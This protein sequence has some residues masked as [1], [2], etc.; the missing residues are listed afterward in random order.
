MHQLYTWSAADRHSLL[1]HLSVD[2]DGPCRLALVARSQEELDSKLALAARRLAESPA[3]RWRHRSGIFFADLN[4]QRGGEPVAFLFPGQGSEYAGMLADARRELP[5]VAAWFDELDQAWGEPR[6]SRF[7]ESDAGPAGV[8]LGG[9]LSTTTGLALAQALSELGVQVSAMAGPSS[10]ENAALICAGAMAFQDRRQLFELLHNLFNHGRQ[11]ESQGNAPEADFLA[12]STEDR[13]LVREILERFCDQLWVALDN[14][15]RQ[16][17]L[18]GTSQAILAAEARL[19]Q[20]GAFSFR[21][22]FRRAYHTPLY[23]PVARELESQVYPLLPMATPQIPVYSC[24][25]AEPYPDDPEAIR[26]LAAEQWATT[27]RFRET[28][29]RM[30]QDG[31]RHFIEVGPGGRLAGFVRDTLRSLPHSAWTTAAEGRSEVAQLLEVAAFLFCEGPARGVQ[32][33]PP[34]P[35]SLSLLTSCQME[36]DGLSASIELSPERQGFLLDHR[37][38]RLPVVPFSFSLELA[39]EAAVQLAGGVAVAV[40][41]ARSLRWLA[42]DHDRLQVEV[43]ARS[44]GPGR[45]SVQIL[46]QDQLSFSCEVLLAA[47]FPE[48]PAALPELPGQPLPVQLEARAYNESLFHGEGLL[49]LWQARAATSQGIEVEVRVPFSHH[50]PWL[51]PADTLDGAGHLAAYWLLQQSQRRFWLFPVAVERLELFGPPPPPRTMLTCRLQIK[52]PGT[53]DLDWIDASGAVAMRMQGFAF[54]WDVYPPHLYDWLHY[55]ERGRRLSQACEEG[56]RL[57]LPAG[58]LESTGGIWRRA[59]VARALTARERLRGSWPLADWI[60]AKEAVQDWAAERGARLELD[61]IELLPD[62]GGRPRVHGPALLDSLEVSLQPDHV[63]VEPGPGVV[64][65]R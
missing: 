14:C 56:R 5:G 53:A 23:A 28:L 50:E 51:L 25:R 47:G 46:E 12:V 22:P 52:S 32:Q 57:Q 35:P 44:G 54:V 33:A 31:I 39:A 36:A 30:H 60:A 34:P 21:L 7:L 18:A 64:Q 63:R 58:Y 45:V 4:E 26:A 20:G 62:E 27:V 29:L 49:S 65:S 37:L 11:A 41:N 59:L 17:V 16:L 19:A 48:P 40:E 24:A 6:P 3:P 8:D 15:P 61:Q 9:V 13:G 10:G 42:L 38:G 43:R 55:P 2:P 1:S